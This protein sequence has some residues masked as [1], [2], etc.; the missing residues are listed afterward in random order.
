MSS[1]L[2]RR[3]RQAVD[4]TQQLPL[5]GPLQPSVDQ[6][7]KC[8]GLYKQATRGPCTQPFPRY[9]FW[10]R[11][12]YCIWASEPPIHALMVAIHL[13]HERGINIAVDSM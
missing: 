1:I 2:A 3:F 11:D 4:I 5:D 7:Y 8:Y 9:V 12:S 13:V 6:Q 10:R